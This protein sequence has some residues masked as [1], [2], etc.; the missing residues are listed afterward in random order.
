MLR[1][2]VLSDLQSYTFNYVVLQDLWVGINRNKG[3]FLLISPMFLRILA[4][5]K[6]IFRWIVNPTYTPTPTK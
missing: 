1:K 4:D 5:F 2:N 6:N 3:H